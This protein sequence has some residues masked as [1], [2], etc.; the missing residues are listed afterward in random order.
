MIHC[1]FIP[2]VNFTS[3]KHARKNDMDAFGIPKFVFGKFT[4]ENNKKMMPFSIEVH[5]ALMDGFHVGKFIEKL[6]YNLNA[7]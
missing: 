2:W 6:Q 4:D 7:L 3:F 1:S 5:H